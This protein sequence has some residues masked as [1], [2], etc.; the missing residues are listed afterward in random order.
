MKAHNTPDGLRVCIGCRKAKPTSE[1]DFRMHQ[2][3]LRSRCRPCYA[4]QRSASDKAR[5]ARKR[6]GTWDSARNPAPRPPGEADH[7][8]K[9]ERVKEELPVYADHELAKRLE[10]MRTLRRGV[11]TLR[12]AG[13][14]EL[15]AER[16]KEL[17]R[18]LREIGAVA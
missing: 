17:D 2:G 1:F 3:G 11:A 16:E 15:A 14:M 18:I 9:L 5:R 7:R 8:E 13:H 12:M 6:A 10:R 4:A